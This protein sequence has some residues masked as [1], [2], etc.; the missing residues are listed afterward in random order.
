[1]PDPLLQEEKLPTPETPVDAGSQA[2]SEALRS[3]FGIVKFVMGLLVVV[4]AC[5]GFFTVGPQ[6]QAIIIRL[7]KPVGEREKALLGP[8]FHWSFPYPIDEYRKIPITAIQKVSSTVGWYATTA[9][10][11]LAGTEMASLPTSYPL[12][13]LVDGYALTADQNIVHTRATLTYHIADP[14]GFIFNFVNAS[15]AVQNALDNALLY[16]AS[17]FKVD[18]LLTGDVT[19]FKEAVRKRVVA[20]VE[21]QNLGVVVEECLVQS[22]A[23]R[24]LKE[25]FEN[26][27]KAELTRNKVLDEA[28]TYVD[29]VSSKAAADVQSR[30]N[31]AESDRARLVND[32]RSQAER[33]NEVLPK[34]R[35]NPS[36]FVQQRLADTLGRVLTNAQETIFLTEGA[37]GNPREVRLLINRPP[38]KQKTGET[39]P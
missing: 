39:K 1:M 21:K 37:A 30:I 13:P 27:L 33:F 18:D 28:R 2:L 14:V 22:R 8:G 25:A 26:V 9:E 6:E 3:S 19:G 38:P 11:E 5:S 16:A 7:G 36:L 20:L 24:Q 29:Q 23:P 4:F 35:A 15:N 31:A 34:Y 17:Q 32:V 12:N 10:Q